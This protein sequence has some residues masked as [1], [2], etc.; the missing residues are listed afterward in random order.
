[1]HRSLEGSAERGYAAVAAPGRLMG[2]KAGWKRLIEVHRSLLISVPVAVLRCCTA[3]GQLVPPLGHEPPSSGPVSAGSMI[4]ISLPLPEFVPRN[5]VIALL[6]LPARSAT[7]I[8]AP[9]ALA[10]V[11]IVWIVANASRRSSN[12][13]TVTCRPSSHRWAP[14][15]RIPTR[16][17]CT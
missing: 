15:C 8:A 17:R 9:G 2:R 4:S 16:S 11:M 7:P 5:F 6:I 3:G 10:M 14:S 13:S 1:M 12:G